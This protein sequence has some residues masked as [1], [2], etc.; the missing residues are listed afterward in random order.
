MEVK[1]IWLNIFQVV[2]YQM[3]LEMRNMTFQKTSPYIRGKLC[4]VKGKVE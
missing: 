2:F 4:H 3:K 1:L